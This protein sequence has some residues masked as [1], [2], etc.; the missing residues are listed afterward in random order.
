MNE[1]IRSNEET[2]QAKIK[3]ETSQ[4]ILLSLLTIQSFNILSKLILFFK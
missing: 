3:D 1:Q 4:N 2:E